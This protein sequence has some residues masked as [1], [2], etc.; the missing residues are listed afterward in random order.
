M[1]VRLA[2]SSSLGVMRR[3]SVVVWRLVGDVVES[4][5]LSRLVVV[6]V[7]LVIVWWSSRGVG[8]VVVHQFV[9][10]R[11]SSQSLVSVAVVTSVVVVSSWSLVVVGLVSRVVWL[12]VSVVV[13]RASRVGWLSRGVVGVVVVGQCVSRVG[14]LVAW[15]GAERSVASGVAWLRRVSWR[16][17]VALSSRRVAWRRRCWRECVGASRRRVAHRVAW[18]W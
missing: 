5:E 12:V 3:W 1:S 2:S 6:V 15:R 11:L 8:S 10:G 13:S 9:V 4:F 14:G 16:R 7:G 18:H 17:R